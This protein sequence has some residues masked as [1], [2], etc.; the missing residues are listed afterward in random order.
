VRG[1]PGGDAIAD[2]LD[3]AVSELRDL[4]ADRTVSGDV[5]VVAP[6]LF[7]PCVAA[8]VERAREGESLPDR[9]LFSLVAFLLSTGMDGDD[10]A[11]FLH[12]GEGGPEPETVEGRVTYLADRNGSQYPPPSCATMQ[13]YG[14]CVNRDERCATISHPLSYYEGAVGDA[15]EV[16]DWREERSA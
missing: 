11:A 13:A 3:G 2:A 12:A 6:D 4:L 7:P 8:L 9:S 16:T 5:D 1:N 15:D 10:V 14:D